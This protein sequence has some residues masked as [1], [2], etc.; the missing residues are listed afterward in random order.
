MCSNTL[1][2]RKIWKTNALEV[3]EYVDKSFLFGISE[4]SSNFGPF[5]FALSHVIA[6]FVCRA[7]DGLTKLRRQSCTRAV[8]NSWQN[9]E[10]PYHSKTH[11]DHSSLTIELYYVSVSSLDMFLYLKVI[12]IWLYTPNNFDDVWR[13][14]TSLLRLLSN[15]LSSNLHRCVYI[16]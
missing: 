8:S 2:K 6:I 14:N 12:R 10:S 16:K 9:R 4:R 3:S 5:K 1:K 15:N 13:L 11:R 7:C